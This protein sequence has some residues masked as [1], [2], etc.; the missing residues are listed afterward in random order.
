MNY[1]NRLLSRALADRDLSPL[2][3]RG[4]KDTW[5]GNDDDKRVW[6]FVKNHYTQY[7]ECPSESVILDNFP[8]YKFETIPDS[9]DYLLDKVVEARRVAVINNAFREAITDIELRQDHEGAVGK[10]QRGIARMDE[11]GLTAASDL[12]ITLD[13]EKRWDDYLERKALPGG[14]RGLPTGFPSIDQATSGMQ[15]G[16]LIVVVAPPKTGKSTLLLQWAHNVHL[17]GAVPVFQS[18]EMNNNEQLNRYDAMRARLSHHRLTTGTLTAEEESRYQAKLRSMKQMRHKFW[19]T[20][21][22]AANTI[23][24]ISNKIQSLQPDVM[25]IDGVYLMTDEQSGER[26][27]SLALTNITRNLKHVAQQFQIPIVISTQVLNW[28]MKNGNVTLDS[29][30]YSS[31]F[32]QDADVAYALQKED[33]NVDDTRLLKI[34]ASRNTSP[35]ETSLLWDWATGNFRELDK[36]DL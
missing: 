22:V 7:H 31:S 4:V 28:K 3:M 13:A 21:S 20:D 12:D 33:E 32:G 8:T 18:F 5:F 25:F 19:L 16:Q 14:L 10:I 15:P 26:N 1:E 36:D 11:D 27:T 2:F 35:M 17:H 9:I 23:S 30:G 29:I 6:N 24:G 34:L